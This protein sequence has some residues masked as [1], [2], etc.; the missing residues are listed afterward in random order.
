MKKYFMILMVIVSIFSCNKKENP[1]EPSVQIPELTTSS[2]TNITQTTASSGGNITSDGGGAI[3]SRGVCWSTKSTPT[4]SDNKTSDGTGTGNFTSGITGLSANTTYYVRAYATNHVGTGYGDTKSF[5]TQSGGGGTIT[6]IDGNVYH[7]VTIG[8]QVWMVENLKTTKYR[9]GDPIPNVTD[10]TA[11]YNLTTG[12]YCN[13]D[14]NISKATTYGR[15]YNWF[16]VN[17]NRKIAPSGWHVPTDEEWTTL[18]TFLGGFSVAGGKLKEAGLAHWVSPNTGATNETGFTALPGGTRIS[19][20][21]FYNNGYSGNWWSS[22]VSNAVSA[23]YRY[24]Y[25]NDGKGLRD[26]SINLYGFSVR[27]LRDN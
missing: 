25:Y 4:I 10:N 20:G 2:V 24:L 18:T 15:L 17:D 12:A 6:D 19:D 22:T 3:T 11:W 7:T 13:Y 23:W 21:T 5:T 16:A 27:C 14:N 1:T 9:N 8:S 26:G